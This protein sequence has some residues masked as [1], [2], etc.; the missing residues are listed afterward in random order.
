MDLGDFSCLDALVR[1]ERQS[2][3]WSAQNDQKNHEFPH[4]TRQANVR[5]SWSSMVPPPVY[6]VIF[7]TL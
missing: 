3:R 7:V 4:D 6:I 1:S 5:S 2:A